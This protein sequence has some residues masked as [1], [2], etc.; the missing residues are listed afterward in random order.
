VIVTHDD[1]IFGFAD[2]IATMSDGQIV[3]VSREKTRRGAGHP[4][5]EAVALNS[6]EAR[7]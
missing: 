7:R 5:E 4:R 1:R 2:V 3:K 6:H